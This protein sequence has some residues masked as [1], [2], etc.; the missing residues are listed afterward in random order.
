M[1]S[2]DPEDSENYSF[3][4]YTPSGTVDICTTPSAAALFEPGEEVYV[5]FSRTRA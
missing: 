4:K 5:T 3:G 1:T 2:D